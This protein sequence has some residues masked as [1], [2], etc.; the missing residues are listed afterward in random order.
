MRRQVNG[1]KCAK[2]VVGGSSLWF[3]VC[4]LLSRPKEGSDGRSQFVAHPAVF[5]SALPCFDGTALQ[6]SCTHD[7][8]VVS[9]K[10]DRNIFPVALFLK[11]LCQFYRRC[12]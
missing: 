10:C 2:F 6:L 11:A 4:E 5:N 3:D 1:E 8:G 7:V 12:V 9:P